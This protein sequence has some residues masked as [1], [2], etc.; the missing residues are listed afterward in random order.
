M[1]QRKQATSES[2]ICDNCYVGL[3]EHEKVEYER[4]DVTKRIAN[5]PVVNKARS[6][7]SVEENYKMIE[8]LS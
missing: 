7:W 3:V 1:F 5:E 4:N 6:N 2:C 8:G